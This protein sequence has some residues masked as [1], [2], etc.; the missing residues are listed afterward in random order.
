MKREKKEDKFL[1]FLK[2]LKII[3]YYKI[4]ICPIV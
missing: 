2:K 1:S 4:Y 3:G